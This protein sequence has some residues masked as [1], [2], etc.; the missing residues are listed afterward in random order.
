MGNNNRS[1]HFLSI[2]SVQAQSHVPFS[3]SILFLHQPY[4]VSIFIVS[5]FREVIM[6][7]RGP[8]LLTPSCNISQTESKIVITTHQLIAICGLVYNQIESS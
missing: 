7:H 5:I 2:R 1:Q 8:C 6:A 3:D 4:T